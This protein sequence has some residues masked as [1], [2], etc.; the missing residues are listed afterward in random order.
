MKRENRDRPWQEIHLAF[1]L[2]FKECRKCGKDFR[3][4][5]GWRALVGQLAGGVTRWL[6]VCK[7]CI[8]H[9]HKASKY[10]AWRQWDKKRGRP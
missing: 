1:P 6:Y 4:E 10:F 3:W 8:P 2:R 9:R 5:L 7:S